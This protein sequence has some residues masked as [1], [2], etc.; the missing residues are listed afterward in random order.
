MMEDTLLLK[1]DIKLVELG[2]IIH[3]PKASTEH[4]QNRGSVDQDRYR[5]NNPK[6]Q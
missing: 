2:V 1:E 5:K 6:H 3:C 4:V